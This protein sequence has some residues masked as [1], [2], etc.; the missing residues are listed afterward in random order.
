MSEPSW[1]DNKRINFS[2][3][4]KVKVFMAIYKAVRI[5]I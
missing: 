1:P 3:D 4:E 5:K 2:V